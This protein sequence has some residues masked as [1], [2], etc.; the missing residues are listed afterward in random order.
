[1]IVIICGEKVGDFNEKGIR[2]PDRLRL[3]DSEKI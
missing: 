3:R 1:V 2:E